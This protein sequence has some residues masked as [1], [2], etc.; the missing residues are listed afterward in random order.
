MSLSC[1]CPGYDDF[2]WY[3]S[4]NPEFSSLK[5]TRRKRCCSCK[6][7]IDLGSD[8]LEFGRSREPRTEIE[9][10]IFGDGDTVEMASWYMCEDCGEIFFNLENVGFCVDIQDDM[11]E[12][13]KEYQRE[14]AHPA[15][16]SFK[17]ED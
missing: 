9:E 4:Y 1:S 5:T 3:Y 10:R 8:V 15:W 2:A 17:E 7:L 12:N 6:D 11:R 14:Y 16:Q 13:L